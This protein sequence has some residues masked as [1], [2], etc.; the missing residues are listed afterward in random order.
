MQRKFDDFEN[1]NELK[2]AEAERAGKLQERQDEVDKLSSK[3]E[4]IDAEK[5]YFDES[6]TYTDEKLDFY[7]TLQKALKV[8][9]KSAVKEEVK[10]YKM[11]ENQKEDLWESRE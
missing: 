11:I 10:F 9:E 5:K 3:R 1:Q 6:I 4:E 8:I 7:E 2:K